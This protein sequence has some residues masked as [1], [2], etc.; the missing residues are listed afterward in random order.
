MTR[1]RCCSS[2]LLL[3]LFAAD[4]QAQLVITQPSVIVPVQP[5]GGISFGYR[6]R[7]FS[8]GGSIGGPVYPFVAYGIVQNRVTVQYLAPSIVVAPRR[9]PLVEEYDVSGVDL[10]VVPPTAIWGEPPPRREAARPVEVP[11]KAEPPRK[12][13]PVPAKKVEPPKK[14]PVDDL[15]VPRAEPAAEALRLIELGIRA[16]REEE[17]GVAALRFRQATEVDPASSRALFLLG[18]AEYALGR[19]REAV[20]A[21]EEGM[22]L[23]LDWPAADFHPREELYAGKAEPWEQHRRWLLET[24]KRHPRNGDYLFLLGCVDWFGDRRRE[25]V[26]WFR[27]ARPFLAGR[28]WVDLFLKSPAAPAPGA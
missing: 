5:Y 11:R 8:I 25:A 24:H 12:P 21:I 17:Y 6:G 20:L 13:E 19:Y 26:E 15:W 7:H 18:H 28:P 22:R 16:F 10:D 27:Q 23:R 1:I 2:V 3:A 14:K 4:L 9:A